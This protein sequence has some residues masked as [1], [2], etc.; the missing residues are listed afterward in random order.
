LFL[1]NSS[2]HTSTQ[3][4]A[5][6]CAIADGRTQL[7]TVDLIGGRYVAVDLDGN[8]IGNFPS[9]KSAVACFDGRRR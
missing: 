5:Q 4:P 2:Q 1:K 6:H 3:G 7:S 8:T 9:L